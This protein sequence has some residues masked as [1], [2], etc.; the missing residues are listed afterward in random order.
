[1]ERIWSVHRVVALDFVAGV[2]A[3]T[4]YAGLALGGGL[5]YLTYVPSF[6]IMDGFSFV[7]VRRVVVE[8]HHLAFVFCFQAQ[9]RLLVRQHH[10]NGTHH[11]R[12]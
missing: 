6:K 10:R 9:V 11:R 12:R 5:G 4:G 3:D 2:V 1:M 7:S 8:Q